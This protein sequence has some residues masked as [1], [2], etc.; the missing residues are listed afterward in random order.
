MK[1]KQQLRGGHPEG[2]SDPSR[3]RLSARPMTLV[4]LV[5]LCLA[6]LG[7]SASAQNCWDLC[8]MGLAQCLVLAEGDPVA[9]ARCQDNYDKCGADCM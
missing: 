5:A 8:Q 7:G 1:E 9:E 6:N 3:G 4:L 2:R